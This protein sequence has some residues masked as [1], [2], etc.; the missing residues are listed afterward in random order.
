[1]AWIYVRGIVDAGSTAGDDRTLT[2]LI[3]ASTTNDAGASGATAF[4][5]LGL[6]VGAV[7][8][9]AVIF[10]SLTQH[11]D[12]HPYGVHASLPMTAPIGADAVV[13]KIVYQKWQASHVADKSRIP[14]STCL[15][16]LWA[17]LQAA[18]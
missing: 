12:C 16:F 5:V 11:G 3:Y 9:T 4:P 8:G 17:F 7:A 15:I 14:V 6:Q 13:D 18:D 2:I 1:M 10:Q